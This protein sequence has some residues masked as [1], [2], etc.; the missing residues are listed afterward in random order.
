[1]TRSQG[2][3]LIEILIALTL[4]AIL[5]T[6]TSSIL[7]HA[8]TIRT[9]V[10]AQAEQ[11]SALQMAIS[12]VQQDTLQT[13]DRPVRGN[14][15]LLHAAFVGQAQYMEF[16]RDGHLNPK[17]IEKRS[18]LKRVALLCKEG[19]LLRRTWESLDVV[20]RSK[21]EDKVLLADLVQCQFNYLNQTLQVLSEWRAEVVTQNQNKE[22][23]PKAVQLNLKLKTWGAVSLL[24]IIPGALYATQ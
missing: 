10:N 22:P 7:Y 20:N 5:A 13:V 15:Q 8:F 4:F 9:Q 14:D 2:F 12:I 1:M 16:T 18:T 6:I 11:L 23:S 19:K 21:F 17:S 24:F 3:T